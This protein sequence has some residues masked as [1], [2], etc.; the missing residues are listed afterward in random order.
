MRF[1]GER[2]HFSTSWHAKMGLTLTELLYSV[3]CWNLHNTSTTSPSIPQ[4]LTPRTWKVFCAKQPTSNQKLCSVRGYCCEGFAG[5]KL[6]RPVMVTFPN[7]TA[8]FEWCVVSCG[9]KNALKKDLCWR[10]I[11]LCAENVNHSRLN[12]QDN[13]G[14]LYDYL[15]STRIFTLTMSKIFIWAP[16]V[17]R[18]ITMATIWNWQS[19]CTYCVFCN[20]W[21]VGAELKVTI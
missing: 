5:L 9:C 17:I 12:S 6:S 16:K 1:I 11:G 14:D 15:M 20:L 2:T 18:N 21:E 7:W 4:K 8:M 10:E 13:W 19:S 3:L